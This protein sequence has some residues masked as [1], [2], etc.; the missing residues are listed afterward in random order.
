[1]CSSPFLSYPSSPFSIPSL[2]SGSWQ[3]PSKGVLAAPPSKGVLADPQEVLAH[4]QTQSFFLPLTSHRSPPCPLA[5]L[6]VSRINLRTLPGVGFGASLEL[7]LFMAAFPLKVSDA[8][9]LL[10]WVSP[11]LSTELQL[12]LHGVTTSVLLG[13]QALRSPGRTKEGLGVLDPREM[14]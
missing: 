4:P 12:A 11:G 3:P 9:L 8:F 10:S 6:R 2:P 13:S 1:M 14:T 7:L 5:V